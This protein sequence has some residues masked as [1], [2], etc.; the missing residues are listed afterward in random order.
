[1]GAWASITAR[2]EPHVALR[3][4]ARRGLPNGRA[5]LG[6]LLVT[7]SALG[8][9]SSIASADAPPDT[10]HVVAAR[11]VA[12]GAVLTA[13]DLR[14]VAL[15]LPASHQSRTFRSIAPVI[16]AV[17]LGPLAEGDLVQ[18]A[19]LA[20]GPAEASPTFSVAVAPAAA[21][22]GRI[23]PGDTV[24]V[25]ATYGADSAAATRVLAGRATVV[26]VDSASDRLG[27]DAA[28][29]V[30]LRVADPDERIA[31]IN[32]TVSGQLSLVRTTGVA[33]PDRPGEH[34]PVTA[35]RA[36]DAGTDPP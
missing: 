32:A 1:M 6:A 7:V 23:G 33:D 13:D 18:A 21:D 8:A 30:R 27:A 15:D 36:P 12:P 10:P 25:L 11:R 9:Y 17:S 20:P 34:R 4:V 14:V 2:S 3:V 31:I 26:E 24:Q 5:V 28:L 16:G 22:G 29:T 19:G 35:E